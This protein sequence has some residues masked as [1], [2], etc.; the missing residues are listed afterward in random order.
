MSFLDKLAVFMGL[1]NKVPP[2]TQQLLRQLLLL[3]GFPQPTEENI[4][5]FL[6]VLEE[7][8]TV[9]NLADVWLRNPD[10]CHYGECQRRGGCLP[11]ARLALILGLPLNCQIVAALFEMQQ[12]G[13]EESMDKVQT[14]LKKKADMQEDPDGYC[15]KERVPTPFNG[16]IPVVQCKEGLTCALCQEDPNPGEAIF[17]MPCCQSVY[18]TSACHDNGNILKWFEEH[19]SCPGC[20]KSLEETFKRCHEEEAQ[21]PAKRAK[22]AK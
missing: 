4:S 22:L 16:R 1:P 13:E 20:N 17:K 21:T 6:P 12:M 18:H 15:E 14:Y 10:D 2:E 5:P 19:K 7:E 11:N 3:L 8:L 9:E